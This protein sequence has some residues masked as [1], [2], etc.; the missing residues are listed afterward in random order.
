MALGA[1]ALADVE[2]DDEVRSELVRASLAGSDL[3]VFVLS[4]ERQLEIRITD[5]ADAAVRAMPVGDPAGWQ[6]EIVWPLTN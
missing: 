2:V 4:R 3:A 5:D 1:A 6:T